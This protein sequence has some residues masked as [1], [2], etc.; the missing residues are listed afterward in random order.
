M[1]MESQERIEILVPVNVYLI[2]TQV[3]H[4]EDHRKHKANCGYMY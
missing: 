1:L 3:K 2:S 4:M